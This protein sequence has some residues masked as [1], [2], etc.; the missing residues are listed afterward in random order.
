MV[1]FLRTRQ[2]SQAMKKKTLSLLAAISLASPLALHSLYA[3]AE[4]ETSIVNP[5]AS[6]VTE[7][8]G[9]LIPT[10]DGLQVDPLFDPHELAELA[11]L[12][13]E[14]GELAE[15]KA[16]FFGPRIGTLIVIAII[17]ILVL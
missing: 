8:R 9:E 17:L 5:A 1:Y 12:E 4:H 2:R 13:S 16:G 6:V 14:H 7:T 11:A 3:A 10:P 15:Q